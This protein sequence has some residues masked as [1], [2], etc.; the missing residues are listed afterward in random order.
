MKISNSLIFFGIIFTFSI[1]TSH[2]I[3]PMPSATESSGSDDG[4]NDS[5]AAASPTTTPPASDNTTGPST[6]STSE[7]NTAKPASQAPAS[8]PVEPTQFNTMDLEGISG[9]QITSI[10]TNYKELE[11]LSIKAHEL[12]TNMQ[13]ILTNLEKMRT[14]CLETFHTV[15]SPLDTLLP[16]VGS[17]LGK[18]EKQVPSSNP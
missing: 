12:Q 13:T 2:Q 11:A 4:S 17:L 14:T 5:P 10:P 8:P 7:E 9:K 3:Y 15:A 1:A 18:Y 16:E 6:A